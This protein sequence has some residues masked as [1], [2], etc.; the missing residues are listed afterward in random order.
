M[1]EKDSVAVYFVQVMVHALRAQPERL[2]AVLAEAGIDP[3][4]LGQPE[5]RVPASA[6]AALWLIQI[7]ELQDE[8]FRLDSHGLPPGAF[9]LICRG[10]IQEP[11]L[12]KA[13]RQCLANFGLFLRDFRGSLSVRGKRA[14]LSLDSQPRDEATGRFGE[15]TFLVLMISL[16]CWLGGRRIAI[17]RADFRYPRLSLGDDALLWGPNLTFGAERTEIEFASRFL[18]LPV[19]QDLA[20]LKVFLRSAPQWLVIRFRNQH[21]LATQVYQRLRR[22]HY[23]QWPT[24]EAFAGEVQ[25]SPST[26]RRRL[27]REGVSYQEI[28][29]EVRRA[30]AVE[31]LR[32][33]RASIGEIA[34]RTGFQEP[35]AF[36]RAFK[37]WTGESPGRYRARYQPAT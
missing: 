9:A 19:V 18:R 12:E 2:A 13:L 8:F 36:H 4:L 22:S 28:K 30:M 31:L 25:V 14:V 7:R 23:S 27:E 37:K 20:S 10:L 33:S 26:L 35:S 21:G 5:A 29:D 32:Q 16:L 17:D 3:A 6:F 34:E 1:R 24:L 15:E 11:T